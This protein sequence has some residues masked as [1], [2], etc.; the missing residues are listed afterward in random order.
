MTVVLQEFIQTYVAKHGPSLPKKD[1]VREA[2]RLVHEGLD[3]RSAP[4]SQLHNLRQMAAQRG[5]EIVH[6]TPTGSAAPRPRG[7]A[8]TR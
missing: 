7:H 3:P 8:L 4:G 6:D 2:R 1:G 5:Y